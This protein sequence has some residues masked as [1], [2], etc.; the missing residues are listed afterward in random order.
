MSSRSAE[1]HAWRFPVNERWILPGGI[2][3]VPVWQWFVALSYVVIMSIGHR[4]E[5]IRRKRSYRAA[6]WLQ[7]L[8]C[9][10]GLAWVCASHRDRRPVNRRR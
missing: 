3:L 10:W 7:R 1:L 5:E 8:T 6:V 4:S 9:L 2:V